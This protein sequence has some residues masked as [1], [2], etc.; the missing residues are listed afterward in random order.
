M[1]SAAESE[2]PLVGSDYGVRR[3][4]NREFQ[5]MVV[6]FIWQIRTPQIVDP[7]PGGY[8]HQRIEKTI[9]LVAL[10]RSV[11]PQAFT[12]EHRLILAVQGVADDRHDLPR[13]CQ[14][15]H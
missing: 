10:Q 9:S 6:A 2:V 13:Q 12:S 5:Q 3:T 14:P 1:T 8:A 7:D 4:G 11:L 15:Q